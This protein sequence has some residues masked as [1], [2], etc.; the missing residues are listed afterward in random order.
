M[1]EPKVIIAGTG[2]AGTTLLVQILT[3]L[4]LDTGFS[5][6]AAI[7]PNARAGLELPTVAAH[8]P[9]IVKNPAFSTNLR[10]VLERGRVEIEHVIIPM[11]DLEIA[12]ASRLRV[13]QYGRRLGVPGGMWLTNRTEGQRD[14]LAVVFYDLLWTVAEFDV[15]HTLLAFP[16]FASDADYL[17]KKLAWLA[18]DASVDDFRRAVEVCADPKMITQSVLTGEELRRARLGNAYATLLAVPLKRLRRL[19]RS[20]AGGATQRSGPR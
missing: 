16:R 10:G 8:G 18:P 7:D 13:S 6:S 5:R 3:E 1:S 19:V 4:G 2:R 14:A 20:A 9:R 15:P 11:R 12:A 17:A